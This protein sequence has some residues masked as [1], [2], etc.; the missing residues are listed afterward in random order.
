MPKVKLVSNEVEEFVPPSCRSDDPDDQPTTFGVIRMGQGQLDRMTEHLERGTHK[1]SG[2]EWEQYK[3][4]KLHSSIWKRNVKWVS[5]VITASGETLAMVDNPDDVEALY[6][7]M[8]AQVSQEVIG[9][10]QGISGLDE[11]EAK[12]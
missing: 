6:E 3:V 9:F 5:N 4:A 2:V 7:T 12:N 1:K 10:I 8:P 11:D